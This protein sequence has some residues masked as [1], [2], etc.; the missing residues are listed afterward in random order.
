VKADRGDVVGA[1]ASFFVQRLDV[2]ERVFEF[3]VAV[4]ILF[5]AK[6]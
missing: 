4:S 2:L 1:F 5:V 3:N 6:A